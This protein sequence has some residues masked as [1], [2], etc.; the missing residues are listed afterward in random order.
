MDTVKLKVERKSANYY[1]KQTA[2][3]SPG[4]FMG[5]TKWWICLISQKYHVAAEKN[6]EFL[7][8]FYGTLS[9]LKYVEIYL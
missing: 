3:E 2:K 7:A 1:R 9:S 5:V 8:T 4:D 6:F